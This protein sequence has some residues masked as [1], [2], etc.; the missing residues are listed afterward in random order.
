M[1]IAQRGGGPAGETELLD[2]NDSQNHKEPFIQPLVPQLVLIE[3]E[4]GHLREAETQ[5]NSVCMSVWRGNLPQNKQTVDE[6][7]LRTHA[8]TRGWK[9]KEQDKVIDVWIYKCRRL[10]NCS[11]FVLLIM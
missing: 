11:L 3:S 5:G 6:V 7:V 2:W 9:Y 8:L 10:I 1:P 4:E